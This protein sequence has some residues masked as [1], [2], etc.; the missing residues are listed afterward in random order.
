M[1]YLL[2]TGIAA[3]L[4]FKREPVPQRVREIA[5][6]GHVWGTCMPVLA[7]LW[8]GVEN[9]DNPEPNRK[10]LQQRIGRFRLWPFDAKAA[11]KHGEI[12]ADLRRRGRPIQ[13]IDIQIAAIALTLGNCVVVT[14]DSDFQSIPDL[15][16]EDWSV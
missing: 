11:R 1:R 6:A 14:K 8:F 15:K 13:Q 4:I 5:E 2:D 10:T 9:S 16:V 3:D 12:A 7:E